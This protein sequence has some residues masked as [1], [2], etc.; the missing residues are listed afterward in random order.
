MKFANLLIVSVL[1]VVALAVGFWVLALG[2]KRQEADHLAAQVNELRSSLAESQTKATESLAAR[3]QFPTNYQQIVLLGKAAPTSD[4]T[5]SLLVEL[6]EIAQHSQVRFNS[7]QLAASAGTS[8]TSSAPAAPTT[9]ATPASGSSSA[10]TTASAIPATE[11]AAS[12]LP[13]GATIGPADLAVMPYELTFS[14]DF[15]HVADFI[16]GVDSL[17]HT[18]GHHVAVNGR[19]MTINGFA[20]NAP[21]S[22]TGS[23]KLE[24]SFSV[25]TY[26][27]PAS[28]GLTAGA[29]A[30]APSTATPTTSTTPSSESST[31]TST[32]VDNS[33]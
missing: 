20:L 23:N 10:V 15:F 2:P 21:E 32:P 6:S 14:G 22:S 17:V 3:R 26:L 5:S 19:L 9:A 25:T 31:T 12:L 1:L 8:S 28:Q 24:A 33:K 16:R 7:I 18:G 11:T 4:G 29:T 27:T 13:L 30:S